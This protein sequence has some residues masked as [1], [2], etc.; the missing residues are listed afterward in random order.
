MTKRYHFTDKNNPKG[1]IESNQEL[2]KTFF[3]TAKINLNQ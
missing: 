1:I 2:L 3:F